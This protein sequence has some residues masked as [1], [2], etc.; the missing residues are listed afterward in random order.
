M[1]VLARMQTK[2]SLDVAVRDDKS[3]P[4]T[5]EASTEFF[6]TKT[7]AR[8]RYSHATTSV[9]PKDDASQ[10]TAET[11]TILPCAVQ[12]LST[13]ATQMSATGGPIE[14]ATHTR[15]SALQSRRTTKSQHLQE[16]RYS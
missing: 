16:S 9:Y 1:P 6:Q 3:S 8:K 4:A 15:Q 12:Q 5:V 11:L 7:K 14:D 2:G 13:D 10:H